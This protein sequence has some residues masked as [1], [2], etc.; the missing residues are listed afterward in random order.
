MP[1]LEELKLGDL[2]QLGLHKV[3]LGEENR[4]MMQKLQREQ[5]KVR[6]LQAACALL[7]SGGGV[8]EMQMTNMDE[9]PVEMGLDLEQSL[10]EL[11][12]SSD[13]Q[14]FFETKQQGR[15]FY[16]FVK[17]WSSGPM[18][19]DSSSKPRICSL[20]S[21][22]YRR[23]GT[24]VLLMDSRGAFD[25][26]KI[27]KKNVNILMEEPS[28]NVIRQDINNLD[29]ANLI[30]QKDHLEYGD[31]LRFPESQSIEFKQFSTKRIQE[32]VKS[33]IPE[34]ISAFANTGGGYLFIGVDDK[35]KKV[36]GCPKDIVDP[37]SLQ[38]VIK[39]AIS[40][41][42][43][44]HFCSS[45]PRVT[46]RTKVID[47]F[48]MGKLHSYLCVIKVDPFC[49]V[50]FQKAPI[51]WMVE[52]KKGVYNLTLEKWIGMMMDDDP[53]NLS[54]GPP[55]NKPVYSKKG[56]EHK[57]DLQQLLF[58]VSP[59]HLRY[60][61][62]ALWKE[63]CSQHEGLEELINQQMLSF[64]WGTLIFSRS[65]AVDLNLQEKQGVICDALLIAQNS[66]PTLFTVFEGQDAEGQDYCIHTAF[67]LKQKLVN[68]GGYTGKVCIMTKV[69]HLNP[70]SNAEFMEESG[71]VMDYPWSYHLADAQQMEDLLQA[72]VIVL[73]GFRSF[74]S[75]QLGCEVL[76][77]LTAQQ[78]EI[79]SKNLRKNRELFVH[80]LPGSGKTVMAVKIM[81]KIRNMFH[82]DTNSI[83][84]ICE[85]Q[86]L[87]N[88]IKNKKI[89][90]AV[91]RK[92]FIAG[93]FEEI[94]H[95]I[96]DEAQNFRS[97][98]TD[99]YGK[100]KAI[101]QREKNCPGILWI[102]LDYFQTSHLDDSGLPALSAQYPREELTRMVRNADEIANYL[103]EVMQEVR[104][105]P[106]PN[107]PPG[108][109]EMLPEAEWVRGVQGTLKVEKDL[110]QDEIVTYVAG[111]CKCLFQM[112]YSFKDVA[113]LVS[114][115]DEVECYKYD[116]LRAMKKIRA[117][118]LSDA[119]GVL[120]DHLVL[121][122][123]RRFSGLER[124][125]VF[126]IHPKTNN[127]SILHNILACLASR[128]KQ[129]LYILWHCE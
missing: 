7:N 17:S 115:M 79:F 14:T 50:V 114:T 105:N 97:E 122:S 71:S 22:I 2:N 67:T 52:K 55:L 66:P 72:L 20:S 86:P 38:K 70:Q 112:G 76:N 32:Y 1:V 102:F 121:D 43:I 57:K 37:D 15:R 127:P 4:K 12:Q 90:Q 88:L 34:Y 28:N 87:R 68:M 40:K 118:N 41:L 27:K 110:T 94:Q 29:P 103:K 9:H 77:L 75:D 99:W 124:N 53:G 49:C 45:K 16:I 60:I 24:S 30:F 81:E 78:Y 109:L 80:G 6:I 119:S 117:V 42:P 48:L 59:G 25:F 85:N 83:L 23:S 91:T 63:L 101:T 18:S 58:S 39:E 108:S 107:I 65:W 46:Y 92:T 56:L 95:I 35:S 21:S 69:L 123:V 125:I 84:Y 73:L 100:A 64:S 19:E 61:P 89:C 120:G 44:F 104:R 128:A 106:P 51:S 82:C 126:G 3:T 96:I 54:S 10:R 26:L 8:M 116:L 62:K 129:Q 5:E 36:L 111:T 93:V 33:I 113:V 13:L 31:I 11:I 98:N 74:L 47:V